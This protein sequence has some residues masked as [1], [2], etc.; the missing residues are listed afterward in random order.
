M[1]KKLFKL[2]ISEGL[3]EFFHLNPDLVTKNPLQSVTD[4]R[5][6]NQVAD[7]VVICS[8]KYVFSLPGSLKCAL[9]WCVSS[10]F[11]F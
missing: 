8:R 11:F 2:K 7:S 3:V 5:H 9:D 6:K 4:F 10:Q 1:V